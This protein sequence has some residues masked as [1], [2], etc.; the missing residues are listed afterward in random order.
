MNTDS[1]GRCSLSSIDF[2]LKNEIMIWAMCLRV[3][4]TFPARVAAC[5]CLW[6]ETVLLSLAQEVVTYDHGQANR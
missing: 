6:T 5:S 4:V 2:T 1:I 3:F